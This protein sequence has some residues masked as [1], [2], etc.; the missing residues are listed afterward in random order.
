M[1]MAAEGMGH[2][3]SSSSFS[4]INKNKEGICNWHSAV[5]LPTLVKATDTLVFEVYAKHHQK[6]QRN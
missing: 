3:Y 2:I 5:M 1:H 6:A 4:C